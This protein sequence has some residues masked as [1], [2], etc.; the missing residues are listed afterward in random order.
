ML[1]PET[2]PLDDAAS[3]DIS[4]ASFIGYA[5]HMYNLDAR[6]SN[7]RKKSPADME[8]TP[9]AILTFAAK[10]AQEA[11]DDNQ[12]PYLLAR[13]SPD[14]AAKGINYK[15]VLGDQRLKEFVQSAPD[16]IKVVAHPSQK[17]K[18]GL[19]PR[20]KDFEYDASPAPTERRRSTTPS[21]GARGSDLPPRSIVVNFLQLLSVLDDADAAQVQIPT[22]ILTKL[23]RD[24]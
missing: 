24:R 19:I 23:L 21:F 12:Q 18:I 13:L 4:Q 11:W 22:H 1:D 6:V 20:D 17:A 7:R 8:Q 3:G 2:G 5:F 10:L 14:L 16:R 9:D 15:D